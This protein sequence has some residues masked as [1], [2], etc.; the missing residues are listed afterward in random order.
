M[1]HLYRSVL[2]M[3]CQ[4]ERTKQTNIIQ[5]RERNEFTTMGGDWVRSQLD[6]LTHAHSFRQWRCNEMCTFSL[7]FHCSKLRP[8]FNNRFALKSTG[9][10]ASP[11]WK[12]IHLYEM[13]NFMLRRERRRARKSK[14]KIQFYF[15]RVRTVWACMCVCVRA[16]DAGAKC[17]CLGK[18]VGTCFRTLIE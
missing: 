7:N 1:Q 3:Y 16:P 15:A 13:Q 12:R 11:G 10:F 5:F 18:K 2:S 8:S 14:T 4:G 17:K 6:A 9:A